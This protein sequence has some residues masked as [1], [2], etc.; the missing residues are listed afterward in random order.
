MEKRFIDPLRVVRQRLQ[1]GSG[2][3][4]LLLECGH[5]VVVDHRNRLPKRVRC[6]G[7]GCRVWK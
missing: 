7:Q 4:L 3:D 1:E 6:H 2:C 5:R